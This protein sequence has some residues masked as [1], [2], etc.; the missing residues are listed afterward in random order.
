MSW[1]CKW[2]LRQ[3]RGRKSGETTMSSSYI[4]DLT[5]SLLTVSDDSICVGTDEQLLRQQN[6]CFLY[7]PGCSTND[8]ER[9]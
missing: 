3:Q 8:A 2:M 7:P 1:S 9:E 6:Y 5:V 4:N